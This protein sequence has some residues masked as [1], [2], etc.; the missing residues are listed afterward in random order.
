MLTLTESRYHDEGSGQN[1]SLYLQQIAAQS[2]LTLY[3]F[4]TLNGVLLVLLQ[5]EQTQIMQLS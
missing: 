5:T 2:C 1:L 4:E 3:L